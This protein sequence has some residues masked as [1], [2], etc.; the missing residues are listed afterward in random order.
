M[1]E[2]WYPDPIEPT[3][4]EERLFFDEHER[5]VRRYR[6]AS[7]QLLRRLESEGPDPYAVVTPIRVLSPIPRRH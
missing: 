3:R 1:D 5:A 7:S 2:R 4:D 6:K